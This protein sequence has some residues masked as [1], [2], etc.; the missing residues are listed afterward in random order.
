MNK[1]SKN[2][3]HSDIARI[4]ISKK[5]IAKRVSELAEEISR[6]FETHEITLVFALTGALHFAS[7]LVRAL[8]MNIRIEPIAVQS[9]P[10]R[11]VRSQELELK[12]D[13]SKNL[14]DKHVIFVDDIYD[15]G[16]TAEFVTN[17]ILS[18][19]PASL[20]T[21][22]LLKKDRPDLHIRPADCDYFG[23]EIPDEFVVGYGLD[24]D[25]LYRNLPYIGV[26]A[27]HA[28]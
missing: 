8:P 17:K 19:K 10:D 15:S 27:E 3:L 13:L 2:N 11:S 23:F 21:C 9:Y 24:F 22:M 25:G 7:D 1:D 14:K 4:V 26:L 18:H 16:K 5:Q 12:L 6:E 28:R 20:K